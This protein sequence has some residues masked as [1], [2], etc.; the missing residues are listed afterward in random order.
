MQ[1]NDLTVVSCVRR[2]ITVCHAARTGCES[3]HPFL[4]L[5][6]ICTN[7]NEASLKKKIVKKSTQASFNSDCGRQIYILLLCFVVCLSFFKWERS[8]L[9]KTELWPCLH[10]RFVLKQ[11]NPSNWDHHHNEVING[12][13]RLHV[14]HRPF[15][16]ALT[17]Q[18]SI[19]YPFC[20][21][22]GMQLSPSISLIATWKSQNSCLGGNSTHLVISDSSSPFQRCHKVKCNTQT[23]KTTDKSSPHQEVSSAHWCD[24]SKLRAKEPISDTCRVLADS[25]K[26]QISTQATTKRLRSPWLQGGNRRGKWS[27]PF[28]QQ[29]MVQSDLLA[30]GTWT[31]HQAWGTPNFRLVSACGLLNTEIAPTPLLWPWPR[32]LPS[33]VC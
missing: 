14:M 18:T 2:G 8:Y 23:A 12:T 5:P 6:N 1:M 16:N 17:A 7:V 29:R 20:A 13:F 19:R 4:C 9:R 15:P 26:D 33:N 22:S 27:N 3:I 32:S 24:R 25:L 31:Q 28:C 21:C 30:P 10:Q 11:Q